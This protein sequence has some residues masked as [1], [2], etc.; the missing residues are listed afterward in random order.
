MTRPRHL[1]PTA[2]ALA[3]T[4]AAAHAAADPG[5]PVTTEARAPAQAAPAAQGGVEMPANMAEL[6]AALAGKDYAGLS[7]LHDQITNGDDLILYMNWEQAHVFDGAGLFLSLSY[8]NDLWGLASVLPERSPEEAHAVDE[9]KQTALFMGLYAYELIVLDGARCAD[10]TA[11]GHRLDQLLG[12]HAATFSY[13][14]AMAEG[15]RAQMVDAVQKLEAHTAPRRQND[16]VLCG[17]GMAS[18]I[19]SLGA[20]AKSG[21]APREVPNRPGMIG[22]T[23]ELPAAPGHQALFVAP[24][25]WR[26]AQEKLRAAMP[27]RL[28]ELMTTHPAAPTPAP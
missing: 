12:D 7:R 14:A 9:M 28:A 1:L 20:A 4:T 15:R 11:P 13:V 19:A 5:A 21:A 6:D 24:D 16:D 22:K 27:A 8:M 18:M 25:A 10:G 23:Y 17:G 26:P 3:L 2:I